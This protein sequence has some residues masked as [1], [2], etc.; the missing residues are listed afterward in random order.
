MKKKAMVSRSILM[1]T[2]MLMLF[3]LVPASAGEAFAA[4]NKANKAARVKVSF[5]GKKSTTDA[6]WD[7]N[8]YG[9]QTALKS[10]GKVKKGTAVSYKILVPKSLLK[11]NNGDLSFCMDLILCDRK[12]GDTYYGVGMVN[13]TRWVGIHKEGN[14]AYL[15]VYNEVKDK[16]EG[17]VAFNGKGTKK[18]GNATISQQGKYYVITMK[19]TLRDTYYDFKTGKDKKLNTKK[20]YY[21]IPEFVIHGENCKANGEIFLDELTVKGAKK[22]TVT[23]NK[24]DYAT[25]DARHFGGKDWNSKLKVAEVFY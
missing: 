7:Q 6:A 1:V 17:N 10:K 21:L 9:I 18:V 15:N 23:F 14:M 24:K 22:Q 16:E 3:V 2:A 12:D 13:K 20:N 8:T 19:D 25:V 4:T 5:N 11:T